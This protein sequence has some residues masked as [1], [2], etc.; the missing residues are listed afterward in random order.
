MLSNESQC[1]LEENI[2]SILGAEELAKQESSMKQAAE[3]TFFNDHS[4]TELLF[5]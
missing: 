5:F 1:V 2:A 4:K 3:S